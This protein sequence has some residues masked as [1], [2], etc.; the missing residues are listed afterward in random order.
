MDPARYLK[1][2][3]RR[4]AW[5]VACV[6]IAVAAGWVT[7]ATVAPVSSGDTFTSYYSDLLLLSDGSSDDPIVTNLD[8]LS[9]VATTTPVLERVAEILNYK[10]DPLDLTPS[11]TPDVDTGILTIETSADTAKEAVERANAYEQGLMAYLSDHQE[12][13]VREQI[14]GIEAQ[15]RQLGPNGDPTQLAALNAQKAQL[16]VDRRNASSHL[17]LQ[18]L[19]PP[20][21]V[22]VEFGGVQVQV[23]RTGRLL[24]C[25]A[26][27]LLAGLIL[28][29]LLER[30]DTKIRTR[31][32]AEERFGIPV[33]A[34]I[35]RLPRGERHAIVPV[36]MPTS[37]AADAFRLLGAGIGV[38]TPARGEGQARTVLVT[39]PGPSDGKTTIVSNVAAALAEEG[40]RVLV[41]SADVRRPRLHD[42][43]GAARAP[44]LA[45]AAD[46]EDPRLH[47]FVQTSTVS[48]VWVLASGNRSPRPGAVLGSAQMR[49]LLEQAR[50]HVDWILIDTS[51]LLAATESALLLPEADLVLL[52]AMANKA[53]AT[54]ARRTTETLEQLQVPNVRV[55]LNAAKEVVMPAGYRRYYRKIE[56][57][58]VD[59]R[60]ASFGFDSDPSPRPDGIEPEQRPDRGET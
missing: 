46:Q 56:Q 7:T 4:W 59:A 47:D 17:G 12:A 15:I 1:A 45:E 29:L 35:P 33:I 31:D 44:G 58:A 52:I 40:S 13:A 10:G 25:A 41:V 6:V 9:I 26:L 23:S 20:T 43:F 38:V 18:L 27:G 16:T 34:E 55:V 3:R 5:I 8:T 28:A 30:F 14:A 42:V 60:Q 53:S 37:T 11:V 2:F 50:T 21:A 32:T 51:P 39:S 36:T 57:D 54:I 49:S 24:V 48:N 22:P 19:A